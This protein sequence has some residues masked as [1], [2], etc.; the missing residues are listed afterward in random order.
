MRYHYGNVY[1]PENVLH[2]VRMRYYVV[3]IISVICHTYEILSRMY[4]I[5]NHTFETALQSRD[6][7]PCLLYGK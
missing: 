4:D 1:L 2:V 5:P 7:K 6:T 3:R